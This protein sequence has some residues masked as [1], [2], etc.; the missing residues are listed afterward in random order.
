MCCL[1]LERVA[2]IFVIQ[3]SPFCIEDGGASL[4]QNVANSVAD[5]MASYSMTRIIIFTFV[6]T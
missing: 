4:L 2:S 5:C 1:T 3:E 6:G